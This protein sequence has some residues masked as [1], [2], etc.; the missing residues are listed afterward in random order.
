MRNKDGEKLIQTGNR[1]CI[2]GRVIER[3]IGQ[4]T[5]K[6][7][8]S[9]TGFCLQRFESSGRANRPP[10]PVGTGDWGKDPVRTAQ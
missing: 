10:I 8:I 3:S 9:G 2:V 1:H 4:S 7:S 5:E 6:V